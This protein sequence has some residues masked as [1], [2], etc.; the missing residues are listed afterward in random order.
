MKD[1]I[2]I[3]LAITG[4]GLAAFAL[5]SRKKLEISLA[6]AQQKAEEASSLDLQLKEKE[7][8]VFTLLLQQK[9]FEE[10]QQAIQL[11]EQHFKLL[12]QSLSSQALEHNNKQFLSVAETEIAKW[13]ISAQ[14]D[15]DKRKQSI[16]EMLTPFKETLVKL[17]L[18]MRKYENERKS[19]REVFKEQVR[20]LTD[21][22]KQ[23]KKETEN[24]VQVLKNPQSRGRWGEM[25]LKR[26]VE[27]AGMLNYCDFYEQKYKSTEEASIRPD[28][29]IRLPGGKQIVIDAKVP[30]EAYLE[31]MYNPDE[32][33]KEAKFRDHARH[34]RAHVHALS[35]KSYWEH[36]QP[37]PEFVILFLPAEAF[38]SAALEY[39]PS[40]IEV[41]AEQGVI[42]A[43]PTTLIALLRTVF[44]GWRQENLS[45]QS[46]KVRELG[47]ELYK[48][49]LDM[50]G[51]WS[52][53]GKN[54]AQA[55]ESYNKAVGSLE[56]R[57]LVTARKFKDLQLLSEEV[58]LEPLSEIDKKPRDLQIAEL[59]PSYKDKSP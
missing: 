15:L 56:T 3:L 33:I 32:K 25:Q 26:I 29:L 1:L 19:E 18:E 54:L 14:S 55:V 53:M 52:R 20:V 16:E 11:A 12:F 59:A 30:L 40:L 47:Q 24:L 57:V 38:F 28:L 51:H 36:F 43:T 6:L 27:L 46:E 8:E 35:K 44:Y 45:K 42:I 4:W 31:A 22:E 37:A 9:S 23:L 10:R 7:K 49:L 21:S 41:G 58:D 17:D 34:I 13:R 50:T 39:D 48:R 2:I 5:M